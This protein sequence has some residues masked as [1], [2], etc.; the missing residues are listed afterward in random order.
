MKKFLAILLALAMVFCLA[1]CG[2]KEATPA[3]DDEIEIAVVLKTLASEYWGY[4]KNGAEQAAAELGVK[5]TVVGPGAESDVEGQ[6]AIIEQQIGAG[7]DAIVCA[8]NDQAAAGAALKAAVEAG[9]PV[10]AVDTNVGMDGQTCFVGTDNEAATKQGALWAAEQLGGKGNAVIIYGLE[11]ENTCN[12]RT[13]GYEAGAI[14]GGLTVIEKLSGNATTDG[15]KKTMEDILT[16][17]D[18]I[19][20]VLCYNDDTALGALSAAQDAGRA[21][22]MMIIGFDG[23][24]TAVQ[25][26]IDGGLTATV[27]Q[28]PVVMGYQSVQLA[29]KA[30]K[31]E[32]V[33]EVVPADVLIVDSKN[34]AEFLASL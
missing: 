28:Q 6:V 2:E 31:G 5:V 16:A 30:I 12:A 25:S 10:L 33:A 22:E 34:A 15:A 20:V 26:V 29:L 32:S 7:V 21:D 3:A 27:A 13:A 1:A 19:D 11:G 4:V 17:H 9:I 23:N 24:K 18:D 14:E 8:P